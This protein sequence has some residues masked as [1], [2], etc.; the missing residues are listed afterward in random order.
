MCAGEDY[1]R[2]SGFLPD[3]GVKEGEGDNYATARKDEIK[4]TIVENKI[5]AE[6]KE[7][8]VL[9]GTNPSS[10]LFGIDIDIRVGGTVFVSLFV[11][12]PERKEQQNR[13]NYNI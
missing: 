1:R 13:E 4:T 5:V 2:R 8:T 6:G 9:Q 10:L 3:T 12:K 7:D 11:V